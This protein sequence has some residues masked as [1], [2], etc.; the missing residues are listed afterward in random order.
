MINLTKLIEDIQVCHLIYYEKK[1]KVKKSQ[2][3]KI[4]IALEKKRIQKNT[5]AR[6]I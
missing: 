4:S 6:M 2:K 1:N 3:T 5:K